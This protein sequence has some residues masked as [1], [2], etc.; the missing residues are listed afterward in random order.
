[1]LNAQRRAASQY[2]L[3]DRLGFELGQLAGGHGQ[4]VRI[5]Q[6]LALQVTEPMKTAIENPKREPTQMPKAWAHAAVRFFDFKEI[7]LPAEPTP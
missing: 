1:M 5:S 6:N 7:T 3:S 4:L 2:E